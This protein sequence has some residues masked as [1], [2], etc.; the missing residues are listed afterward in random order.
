[1]PKRLPTIPSRRRWRTLLSLAVCAA[2]LLGVLASR[3]NGLTVEI[4]NDSGESWTNGTLQAGEAI[5]TLPALSPHAQLSESFDLHGKTGGV[6]LI[7]TGQRITHWN[8]PHL[9]TSSTQHVLIQIDPLGK[10]SVK[11]ETNPIGELF[12][13]HGTP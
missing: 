7:L 6:E 2:A 4:R 8:S 12:H 13:P 1:M 11:P 5:R 9:L 3:Q 10:I